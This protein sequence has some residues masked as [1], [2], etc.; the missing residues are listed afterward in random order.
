MNHRVTPDERMG[1]RLL[2][3][4]LAVASLPILFFCGLYLLS[5]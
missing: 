2:I 4:T 1:H 3:A 5:R